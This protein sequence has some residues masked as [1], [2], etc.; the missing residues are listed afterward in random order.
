M[1]FESFTN[2]NINCTAIYK[3][4]WLLFRLNKYQNVIMIRHVAESDD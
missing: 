4:L 3:S 1:D 2:D